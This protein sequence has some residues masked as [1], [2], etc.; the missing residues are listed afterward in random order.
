MKKETLLD[1]LR[2]FTSF[3]KIGSITFG[4]GY[5]MLPILENELV[6]KRKWVEKEELLDYFAIGQTLPGLIA[7]NVATFCGSK[8]RGFLGGAAAA[9]GVV[10]PSII[11]ISVIAAFITNFADIPAVQRVMR[12]MNVGVAALLTDAVIKMGKSVIIDPV[13]LILAIT[14]FLLVAVFNVSSVI[15]LAVA[16]A[17]GLIVKYRAD[18]NGKK[19]EAG[20]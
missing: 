20:E 2:I 15:I 9:L 14:A 6:Q 1:Y 4:G 3:F 11:V 13:T 16:V 8:R 5:A 19:G 12:G 10:A 7:V 17:V 18:G